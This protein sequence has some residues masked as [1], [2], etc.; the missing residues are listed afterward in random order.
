MGNGTPLP[1][2]FACQP[3]PYLPPRGAE[4]SMYDLAA[5]HTQIRCPRCPN[6]SHPAMTALVLAWRLI[7][8]RDNLDSLAQEASRPLQQQLSNDF[9][10]LSVDLRQRARVH[11]AEAFPDFPAAGAKP[12][13]AEPAGPFDVVD[14]SMLLEMAGSLV[15]NPYNVSGDTVQEGIT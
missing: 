5:K 12:A 10:Q 11:N 2:T 1:A 9:K 3:I 7:P 13:A 4:L 8:C 6:P 15:A 14:N